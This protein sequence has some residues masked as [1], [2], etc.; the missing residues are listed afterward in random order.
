MYFKKVIYL[1]S[2]MITKGFQESTNRMKANLG[3]ALILEAK[4]TT[5]LNLKN[6]NITK[7]NVLRTPYAKNASSILISARCL[8]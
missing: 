1:H 2:V 5:N 7:V 4:A 6:F 3:K 8:R